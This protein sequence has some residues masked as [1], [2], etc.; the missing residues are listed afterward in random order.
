MIHQDFIEIDSVEM[1]NTYR[2]IVTR[3]PLVSIID[4]SHLTKFHHIPTLY[5]IHVIT[6]YFDEHTDKG[7]EFVATM[8]FFA[9]GQYDY[10]KVAIDHSIRGWILAFD[11]RVAK[12]TIF[13]N[14]IRDFAF[15][16]STNTNTIRLKADEADMI[17]NCF[18]SMD[19][20]LDNE[21]DHYSSRILIS[22]IAVLLSMSLRYYHRRNQDPKD[23][24]QNIMSRL[25][26]ILDG[27]L[28]KQPS[29]EKELPTVSSIAKQIGITPNYF[30]DIV[31]K[32]AGCSA[33]DYIR[34]F[35]MK[36]ARRL[37]IYSK[38]NINTIAYNMGYK[39]PHHFTRVFKQEYGIT[40]IE[41]RL[42]HKEE[43]M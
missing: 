27:Y 12:D 39:Y 26:D 32:H 42:M 33:H 35:V 23:T 40:P 14:R 31:R 21:I 36:E 1:F 2:G 25:N 16:S 18:H 13:E 41:C 29:S 22:G 4:L 15:F 30:G 37:L 43:H 3:H 17:I 19:R 7:Q 34:G 6:C 38:L 9:P 5:R 10:T 28:R 24:R 11:D 8:K 20:E